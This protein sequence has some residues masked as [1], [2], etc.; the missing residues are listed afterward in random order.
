MFS[1]SICDL[2]SFQLTRALH[3]F[4]YYYYAG[5]K[6]EMSVLSSTILNYLGMIQPCCNITHSL[7][8]QALPPIV[9]SYPG[10]TLHCCSRVSRSN[11]GLFKMAARWLT[12]SFEPC[13]LCNT[14]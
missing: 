14:L 5:S 2:S 4:I 1:I 11:V 10:A 8:V 9:S 13:V 6:N 3:K 12:T 7:F